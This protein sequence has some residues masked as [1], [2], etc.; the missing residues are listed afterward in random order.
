MGLLD[1]H[2]GIVFGVANERS[3]AW[4]IARNLTDHGAVCGFS[5][6]PGDK[7]QTRVRR[8][9]EA[10]G[11]RDPWLFPCDVSKDEDLD[12]LFD[13]VREQYDA[14]DFVVDCGPA[15]NFSCDQF[16]WAPA[17][18]SADGREWDANEQF[19]GTVSGPGRQLDA[20]ERFAHSLLLTNTFMFID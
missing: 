18:R 3:I 12:A 17:V 19:G 6:L 2:K 10:G 15:G 20:W 8:T 5:H 9:L 1:G 4:H 16:V 14:I 11:L 13:A 7:M